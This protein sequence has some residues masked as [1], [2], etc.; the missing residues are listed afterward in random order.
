[1]ERF[2]CPK[3]KGQLKINGK[4]IFS[5]KTLDNRMGL[6][7]MDPQFGVYDYLHDPNFEFI[8]GELVD[9]Y[10]PICHANLKHDEKHSNLAMIHAQYEKDEIVEV[11]F[12]RKV[13]EHCTFTIK[14]N[15]IKSYGKD[16]GLYFDSLCMFK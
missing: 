4:I 7:L 8:K 10:C 14:G 6:I 5:T 13:G 9:F 16:S 1:M 11:L 15:E 2:S 12:S 3:C